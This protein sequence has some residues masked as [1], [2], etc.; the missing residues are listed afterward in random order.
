MSDWYFGRDGGDDDNAGESRLPVP[1][2]SAAGS[3]PVRRPANLPADPQAGETPQIPE[4]PTP[5]RVRRVL[6]VSPSAVLSGLLRGT[7]WWLFS[8]YLIW[9]AAGSPIESLGGWAI[10]AVWLATGL[11]VYWLPIERG[12]YARRLRQP[13]PPEVQDLAVASLPLAHMAG[14]GT[15]RFAVRIDEADVLSSP[16]TRGRTLAISR[17]SLG[18]EADYLA[19]ALAHELG[20]HRPGA[21]HLRRLGYWYSL[22][23]RLVQSVVR[24]VISILFRVPVV[25]WLVSALLLGALAAG[26]ARGG[27]LVD[28][29]IVAAIVG[30]PWLLGWLSRSDERIADRLAVDLGYGEPLLA[31]LELWAASD[32]RRT[33]IENLPAT[34]LRVEPSYASRLKAVRRYQRHRERKAR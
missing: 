7:P 13:A 23:A 21:W 27:E 34:L 2:P 5:P 3:V 6:R 16:A 30:W 14:I 8:G 15:R 9:L 1:R 12:L 17:W 33:G 24:L 32:G 28:P 22:P 20:H 31:V 26:F 4:Q 25:G 18:L 19:A 10:C 11:P 29:L